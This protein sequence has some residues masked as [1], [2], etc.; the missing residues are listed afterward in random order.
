[1]KK[2][3]EYMAQDRLKKPFWIDDYHIQP[4][5]KTIQGTEEG[6][7]HIYKVI[8]SQPTGKD[9]D[10]ETVSQSE[11]ESRQPV[12]RNDV[13]GQ[14]FLSGCSP[15]GMLKAEIK[16]PNAPGQIMVC[17]NYLAKPFIIN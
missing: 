16:T 11:E 2:V 17:M 14:P 4:V 5:S 1:M 3:C 9:K 8:I 6:P 12:K 10:N 13:K 15:A 7:V